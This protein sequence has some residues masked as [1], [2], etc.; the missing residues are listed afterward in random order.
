VT[1]VAPGGAELEIGSTALVPG[2]MGSIDVTL[3]TPG[4]AVAAVLNE[5]AFEPGAVIAEETMA[6]TVLVED[7]DAD[8]L[9]IPV[10]DAGGLPALGAIRIESEVIFY[11]SIEEDTI[12]AA[13][14][15]QS[16]TT[17]AAHAA[18]AVVELPTAV[19]ECAASPELTGLGKLAVFSFQPDQ[20]VP[21]VDC[22]AIRAIVLSLANF[23]AI[24]DGTRLYACQVVAGKTEGTFP[25][26]CPRAEATSP[27]TEP[28]PLIC[29]EGAVVV[30][31]GATPTPSPTP[32]GTSAPTA[33]ATD[34]AATPT[35]TPTRTPTAVQPTATFTAASVATATPTAVE[36]ETA[37]ATASTTSTPTETAELPTATPTDTPAPC[38]GDCDRDG[39][40]GVGELVVGVGVALGRS[41]LH[42]CRPIDRNLDQAVTIDELVAAVG[43]SMNECAA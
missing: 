18:G 3:H 12:V 14:R 9:L 17:A 38:T 23:D 40:V 34:A 1:V 4:E 21:G 32:T 11:G 36:S 6:A 20:C 28:V 37:T 16:G 27:A 5:I 29:R 8:D 42:E 35:A 7:I 33:T 19:P 2:A 39:G 25:L 13:G 41:S 15:G 43:N 26:A 22:S 10:A 24:P 30:G 31:A